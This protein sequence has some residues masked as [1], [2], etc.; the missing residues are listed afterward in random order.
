MQTPIIR[1]NPN[2]DDSNFVDK[3]KLSPSQIEELNDPD[4]PMSCANIYDPRNY[5]EIVEKYE[6]DEIPGGLDQE[7]LQEVLFDVWGNFVPTF[8]QYEW[9]EHFSQQLPGGGF[10]PNLEGTCVIHRRGGKS[11]GVICTVFTP[12]CLTDPGLY[13]HI[14]PTLTQGRGAIWS[15]MG[16]VTRDMSIPAM[17]YLDLFPRRYWR[18]KNNH[19]MTLE[20]ANGSIYRLG[21][22]K[23]TD[24][25]ANHWRGYNPMGI[26]PDEYGEWESDVVGEI[27]APILAQ[28]GGFVFRVGTPKG[29]NQF[30]KDYLYDKEINLPKN[31]AWLLTVNDTY[32]NDGSPIIPKEFIEKELARGVDPE[33]IQ[34]EYYCS[35]KANASGAWYRHSMA[36]VDAE[37][38]VRSVPYNESYPVDW[39]WDLGG[40]GYVAIAHQ[41]WGDYVRIID[42][43]KME[44]VPAGVMMDAVLSK[45]PKVR[46]HYFPHDGKARIDMVDHYQSRLQALR[47]KGINNIEIVTRTTSVADGVQ[48]GKEVMNRCLFDKDK[49]GQLVSDLRNYKK[50]L[51]RA[52]N[53]YM[54]SEVH[55]KHSHGAAAYRT[56]ATAFH[57]GLFDIDN[58][59]N[60]INRVKSKLAKMAKFNH[61]VQ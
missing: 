17:S 23:G 48:V 55:D 3:A 33:I 8:Y 29:E 50:R 61:V 53:E 18:K 41:A 34:Q 21:G 16:R 5:D 44:S 6:P 57:M 25:T 58:G 14:F 56:M 20:F 37:E 2:W 31:K 26:V 60:T 11:V 52:T 30:Y 1:T 12:R 38:R 40:D 54:D 24:G 10:V 27:F 46:R 22:A 7:A 9:Y 32:Y 59:F 13:L 43:V 39:S 51:N 45:Y 35:F 47:K 28:N 42:Y 49:C 36:R 15:G 19:D 4:N